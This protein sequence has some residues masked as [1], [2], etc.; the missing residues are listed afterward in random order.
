MVTAL[1]KSGNQYDVDDLLELIEEDRAIFIPW[2]MG[3][4]CFG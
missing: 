1:E 4:L 3:Q 2:K